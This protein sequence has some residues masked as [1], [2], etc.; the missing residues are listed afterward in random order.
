MMAGREKETSRHLHRPIEVAAAAAVAACLGRAIKKSPKKTTSNLLGWDLQAVC[1]IT[2]EI[3]GMSPLVQV[4]WS[5]IREAGQSVCMLE[6][7][8]AF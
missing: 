1:V 2:R 4:E 5:P 6:R 8:A 7:L 3:C